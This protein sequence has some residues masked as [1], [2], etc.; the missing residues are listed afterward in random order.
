MATEVTAAA[1]RKLVTGPGRVPRRSGA[2]ARALATG[3]AA[4]ARTPLGLW[5]ATTTDWGLP[6][7]G[8]GK[9]SRS[10]RQA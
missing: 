8:F 5:L 9:Q 7:T 2:R 4:A 10:T 3:A 1:P 6:T